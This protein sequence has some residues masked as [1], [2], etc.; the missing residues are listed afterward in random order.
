MSKGLG[1]SYT[2]RMSRYHRCSWIKN[3]RTRITA[4]CD[5]AF[6][7][8]GG[9]K[10]KLPRYFRDRLYRKKFPYEVLFYNKKTKSCEKKI[11]YRYASKNPL[12]IQMQVEVRNRILAEYH[13]RFA[14][15]RAVYPSL[16][17][18]QI[19]LLL[20]RS[21]TSARMDRQK[22]IYSKMSKFYQYNRF[23]NHSL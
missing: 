7:H 5:R 16:S 15:L 13:R 20:T 23:K 6:Y 18:L 2:D 12:S 10:Y 11:V 17:D 9:F 4:V 21:E 3:P 19:D 8:D 14:E 22:D 1:K